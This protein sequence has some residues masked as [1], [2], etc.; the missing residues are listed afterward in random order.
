MNTFSPQL[1]NEFMEMIDF[2]EAEIL[3]LDEALSKE[4][5]RHDNKWLYSK[6]FDYNFNF[7]EDFT[8]NLRTNLD[9]GGED[10]FYS[11]ELWS[12]FKEKYGFSVREVSPFFNADYIKF[13]FSDEHERKV[14]KVQDILTKYRMVSLSN[15]LNSS[16]NSDSLS[17]K[18]KLKI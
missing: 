10:I 5:T 3:S 1:I 12:K 8:K 15:K 11:D 2:L 16:L 17:H 18:N 13:Y 6:G 4:I 7:Y 9:L 14:A